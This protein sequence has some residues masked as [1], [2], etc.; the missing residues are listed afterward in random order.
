MDTISINVR[1]QTQRFFI[2]VEVRQNAARNSDSGNFRPFLKGAIEANLYLRLLHIC[3]YLCD[4]LKRR[5]AQYIKF[6]YLS[7]LHPGLQIYF[8]YVVICTSPN[9]R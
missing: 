1:G 7:I 6:Y 9:D 2:I 3:R 5:P 4:T 8:G